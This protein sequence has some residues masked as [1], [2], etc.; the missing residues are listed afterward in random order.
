MF[1]PQSAA[2]GAGNTSPASS[3][4]A[5][6]PVSLQQVQLAWF[7]DILRPHFERDV[8]GRIRRLMSPAA[9]G[10]DPLLAFL[11]MACA[12]D[13]LAGYRVGGET[14]GRDYINFIRD[15]F[16]ASKYDPEGLY[17]SLRNGLV[18]MFTLKQKVYTMVL[19]DNNPGLHLQ[20]RNGQTV[21]NAQDF[22]ADL[23]QA[24]D[25]FFSDVESSPDLLALAAQ[26]GQYGS[27]GLVGI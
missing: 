3:S 8:F 21:L 20:V 5:P 9:E 4:P 11:F 13:Y 14:K 23:V 25:R 27:M 17:D 2:S 7:Q 22:F 10:G 1:T 6:N 12:I 15:Y 19:T 26:R 18:H 24:K 16:P